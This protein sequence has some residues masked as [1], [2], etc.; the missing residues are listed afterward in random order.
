MSPEFPV[1]ARTPVVSYLALRRAV[2]V[3]GLA[4]PVVLVVGGW[5]VGVP[6]QDDVSSYYHTPLRDVFVGTLCGAAAFLFCYQG[7]G[8][9]ENWTANVGCVAALGAAFFPIDADSAPPYTR[10]LPGLIHSLSG[11]L[12]FLTLGCYSLV[13]FPRGGEDDGEEGGEPAG[14]GAA[15][16]K[17]WWRNVVYRVSGIVILLATPAMGAYLFLFPDAWRE[18]CDRWNALFW[19]EGTAAW[20][21]AAAWLTKGR[22]IG[23]ELALDLL[24]LAEGR[25]P[26]PLRPPDAPGRPR[27]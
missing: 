5:L 12:F 7:E 16:P 26:G 17:G 18:A 6:V 4:F 3:T 19:L 14:T 20:A 10:T 23:A 15:H 13:H 8:R 9:A 22:A 27:R 25:L 1:P 24:A 11:G 21:F 2:G